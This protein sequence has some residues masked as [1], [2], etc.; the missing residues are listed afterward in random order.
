MRRDF[1]RR[2]GESSDGL[3]PVQSQLQQPFQPLQTVPITGPLVVR[4]D[5]FSSK[6]NVP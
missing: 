2:W 5:D 1:A 6:M 4:C 3:I